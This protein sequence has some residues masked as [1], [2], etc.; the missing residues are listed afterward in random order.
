MC[1]GTHDY[2]PADRTAEVKVMF[3]TPGGYAQNSFH[4]IKSTEWSSTDLDDLAHAMEDWVKGS[5]LPIV[6][7]QVSYTGIVATDLSD[8]NG[9]QVELPCT[10]GCTGGNGSNVLPSN[11]TVAIKLTTPLRGRSYRGRNFFVG[12]TEDAV[13]GDTVASGT[14]TAIQDAWDSLVGIDAILTGAALAIVSYCQAGAWLTSAVVTT[15][16]AASVEN[17]VDSQRRRLKGR[18]I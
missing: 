8:S 6:S 10:S 3:Q 13:S 16:T 17:T 14:V 4:F 11:V 18:G 7:G 15:V 12:L 5:Y 9:P 2:I 1:T